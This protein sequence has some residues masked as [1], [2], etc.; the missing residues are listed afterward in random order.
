M[1]LLQ[2][3][4]K[5]FIKILQELKSIKKIINYICNFYNK[6]SIFNIYSNLLFSLLKRVEKQTNN[7]KFVKK[8]L[9]KYLTTI[10]ARKERC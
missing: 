3:S 1:L 10:V 4:N 2:N 6:K 8:N 7:L 5:Y 9:N